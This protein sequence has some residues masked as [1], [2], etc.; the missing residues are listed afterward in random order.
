MRDGVGQT[1]GAPARL[2]GHG[3]A[4]GAISVLNA[5]ATGVGCSLAIV[6]G[7]EATWRWDDGAGMRLDA[8]G[9][10][11][12]LARAVMAR[13]PK[14]GPGAVVQTRST[15]PPSRGL[16]TSSSAAAA[17]VQAATRSLG[18]EWKAPAIVEAAVAACRDAGITITGALDDQVAVTRGG[19]VVVD[20]VNGDLVRRIPVPP[21]HV[22]VWVPEAHIPKQAAAAVALGPITA[23]ME[24]LAEDLVLENLPQTLTDNGRLF[25]RIYA[26]HGLPVRQEPADVALAHGALGAGLSGTGPAVAALFDEPVALPAVPGGTWAW[27]R[28]IP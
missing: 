8:A 5:T 19:C 2:V 17:L 27:S 21:W 16:K 9:V 18:Y 20:T 3:R 12:R 22:A 7:V 11:D 23:E 25:A 28:V 10:D 15:F 24:Q 1:G 4:H 6:G 13:L 14:G 26:A